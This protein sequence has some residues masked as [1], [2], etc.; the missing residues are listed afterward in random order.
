MN[1]PF[2]RFVVLFAACTFV[3]PASTQAQVRQSPIERYGFERV[4]SHDS[5]VSYLHYL[6]AAF[7]RLTVETIGTTVQGRSIPMVHIAPAS[8]GPKINVLLFCQQHGNEPSGKE[9]A[10]MLLGKLASSGSDAAFSNLDIFLIPSVNP[11]GNEA[12][13]RANANG[14]DLN[15]DHLLLSQPEVRAVHNAFARVNPEVTLDVHEYS[16][17]RREFLSA[18]YVRIADEQ[19]GAPTNLNVSP[20]IVEYALKQLFPFLEKEL[21]K[22]GVLFSNYYKMDEPSD[23]VRASTTSIDDGRQSF[24]ILNTFSFILEGKNGRAMNDELE[25]RSKRQLA[26]IEAFL[27]FV[28]DRSEELRKMV[29]AERMRSRTSIDSVVVRM[30][31]QCDGSTINLPM[32]VLKS[33]ADT[34]VAMLFS[35]VVKPLAS[36]RPPAAYLIPKSRIDVISLLDRHGIVY[37]TVTQPMKKKGEIYAVRQLDQVWMENKT[38]TRVTT[39]PRLTDVTLGIGDVIVSLDQRAGRMLAIA[40]EPASMWGIVQYEE[41]PGLCEIG[42]DY[43]II[44]ILDARGKQ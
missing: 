19:F 13:K 41:F 18:G 29:S 1:T 20:K 21:A 23:T 24:A 36:V 44:R 14:T 8:S 33:N 7:P 16:A 28:N 37:T 27:S 5:L 10:L 9:A 11:D 38:N 26:A 15:R 35:P 32:R 34:M 30:D 12:G 17:Y 43:P 3:V 40:L 22:R 2:K 25:R 42:K 31:Y 39:H 4:T 6:S